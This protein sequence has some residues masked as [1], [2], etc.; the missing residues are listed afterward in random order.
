MTHR[1]F[2]IASALALVLAGPAFGQDDT[3][4][5]TGTP[6]PA[7]ENGAT[8]EGQEFSL[9]IR[10]VAPDDMPAML[11]EVNSYLNGLRSVQAS[12]RQTAFDMFT[13]EVLEATGSMKIVPPE[14]FLRFEYD[15]PQEDPDL[16]VSDGS[17]V[18]IRNTGL[19]CVDQYGLRA[20]PI[21]LFLRE[22][23][24]LERDADIISLL[25]ADDAL[26]LTVRDK[27]DEVPGE[28]Q[29]IFAR[30]ELELLAWRVEDDDN[31]QTTTELIAA[32]VGVDFSNS[33]F[34]FTSR[35]AP[36]GAVGRDGEPRECET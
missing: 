13:G 20:T 28:L 21:H 9:E 17:V 16:I 12:F 14:G 6:T 26:Y 15:P 35:D 1:N 18:Y 33:E 36:R 24:N 25:E 30:P 7:A 29:L 32:E 34:R 27:D 2:F 31:Q 10:E 3:T 5:A 22:N 19:G 23:V 8:D 11:N 4:P